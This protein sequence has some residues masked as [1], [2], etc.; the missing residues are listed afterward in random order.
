MEHYLEL[1]QELFTVSSLQNGGLPWTMYYTNAAPII[2][3]T[4]YLLIIFLVPKLFKTGVPEGIIKPIMAIWNLSLSIMS[5]VILVG[6]V[7]PYSQ[8]AQEHGFMTLF[9]DEKG[10]TWEPSTLHFWGLLFV[11]SKYFEL[12]DTVL[13]LAKKPQGHIEF[14]HWWH[15]TTVLLFTWYAI[16]NHMTIGWLFGTI[17]ACVHTI[18][19]FYYFLMSIGQRPKWAIYL[20]LFQIIQMFIGIGVNGYWA[21]LW[22]I[23]V[24][25]GCERP[26]FL[27]ICAFIMYASYL[28]LFV[29]FFVQK[30]SKKKQV[31]K[32]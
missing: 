27:I 28:I 13:R 21:Y 23:G 31:K 12:F 2:A 1:Y 8:K 11:F 29:Q 19:Y 17:N 24:D 10:V 9:C 32:E 30:Y 3:V 7:I 5:L 22:F 6:V 25:C 26:K 14:L 20:T 18:M 16:V 4:L 15:H